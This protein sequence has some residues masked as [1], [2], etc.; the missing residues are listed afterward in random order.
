MPG[1]TDYIYLNTAASGLI[2][3]SISRRAMELQAALAANSSMRAEHWK[4]EELPRIRKTI[5][6]FLGAQTEN[7]ALLPNFSFGINC[8][9][10]AL[11]GTEKVLLYRHDYPSLTEP[12]LI[13]HFD[14]T[15]IDSKDGFGIDLEEMATLIEKKGIDIVA[16]SHVQ[17]LSGFKINIKKLGSLCRE[18]GVSFIVDATQ[19][20][21]ALPINMTD[22]EIDV[23]IFS[24]YKWMNAGYGT[25]VM[26][27]A[28][29]F[30]TKYPP[31]VG[32]YSSYVFRNNQSKYEPS[33]YNYEPGHL[34]MI[35][36]TILEAAI[37]AKQEIGLQGI[38][39]HNDQL[40]RYLLHE[41]AALSLQWIGPLNTADRCSIFFLKDL[42]GLGAWLSTNRVIATLRNDTIRISMHY[43]NTQDEVGLLI[44]C[45]RRFS[46]K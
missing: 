38:A 14:I 18:H 4:M 31:V 11:K 42:D 24:N 43:Y 16:I 33:I 40:T 46:Q 12:F 41:I 34:N 20:A 28:S 26:Y 45:L 36:L 15:W 35:G 5:A 10:Q 37:L 32:G 21:G 3:E 25:G 19:S 2:P 6:T 13:D 1:L 7:L 22:L 8:V 17:W 39:D 23:L 27:M 29:S 9:V 30:L 44:D